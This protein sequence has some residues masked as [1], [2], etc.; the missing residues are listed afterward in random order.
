MIKINDNSIFI[1]EIKQILKDFNLPSCCI[2]DINSETFIP[3]DGKY[4]IWN[5]NIY[6]TRY[7]LT[8]QQYETKQVS[9]YEWGYAYKGLTTNLKID[10]VIYDKNTHR[11]L[12]NFLRLLRD[13]RGMNLMS[14]YNLIDNSS[15]DSSIE[16]KNETSQVIAKF[17]NNKLYKI[18]SIS[19][20]YNQDY[21]IYIPKSTPIEVCV[22][23]EGTNSLALNSYKHY[24]IKGRQLYKVSDIINNLDTKDKENICRENKNLKMLIK[25]P[26]SLDCIVVLEG[27]YT[28]SNIDY[29]PFIYKPYK[30]DGTVDNNI[31]TTRLITKPQLLGI[32]AS[33]DTYVL[34]DKIVE[35][36][37]GNVISDLSEGYDIIKY[38]KQ[39]KKNNLPISDYYSVWTDKEK[40]STQ[41]LI[42][43]N[44][45]YKDYYDMLPYC[46]KEVESIFKNTE[47][48]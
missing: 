7:N 23:L 36:L 30:E 28:N 4:T 19:I 41:I 32:E 17:E 39:L 34:A 24:I 22:Y 15:I 16:I 13:Y 2:E 25:V 43:K 44:N 11:Y 6:L 45:L 1:G 31:L 8:T 38:Q 5:H 29:T 42:Y 14:M 27:D 37:T 26:T 20:L 48:I 10:N 12:G 33:T 3:F 47:F 46:D 35:Y 40:T 9:N 21:T 18:Y